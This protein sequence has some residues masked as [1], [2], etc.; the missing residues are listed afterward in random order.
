[1]G[2]YTSK[3]DCAEQVISLQGKINE[4]LDFMSLSLFEEISTNNKHFAASGM[5]RRTPWYN[6]ALQ[7]KSFTVSF[8]MNQ[9]NY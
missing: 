9:D 2:N 7:D 5:L 1:M 3:E 4:P 6:R 8:L